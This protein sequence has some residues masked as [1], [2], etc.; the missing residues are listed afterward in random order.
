M[1][2]DVRFG[3]IQRLYGETS[4]A[5]LAKAHVCVLGVGGVGSW[6]V[7]ALARTGVGHLTLVDLDEVCASNINRQLHALTDTIGRSK[8][9]VL[10]ERAVAINPQIEVDLIHDFFTAVTADAILLR[11]YDVVVDCID[12]FKNKVLLLD[13]CRKR[14]QRVVVV[15]G[16]GGRKDPNRVRIADIAKSEGDVMLAMI[17]KRLRQKHGFPR[18][19]N[20]GVNCVYSNESPT[21][22]DACAT[23]TRGLD[24]ASGYGAAVFVTGTFGF[25]AAS[26]VVEAL[27]ATK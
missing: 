25:M 8:I 17:R 7:E 26:A 10:R 6:V 13:L 5:H 3:G 18:T 9:D 19:G 21:L 20:W 16:A 4:T 12:Q 11:Q 15:G 23:A 14:K 1:A 27:L 22:P 2:K 24:C